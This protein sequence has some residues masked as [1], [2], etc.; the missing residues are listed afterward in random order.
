[1]DAHKQKRPQSGL[2]ITLCGLRPDDPSGDL[3]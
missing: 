3:P 2:P 1:M